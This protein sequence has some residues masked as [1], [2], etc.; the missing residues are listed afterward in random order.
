M[1]YLASEIFYE[2][3]LQLMRFSVYFKRIINKILLF[4]YRNNDII[5]ARM[6]DSFEDIY[7]P[8]PEKARNLLQYGALMWCAYLF[9]RFCLKTFPKVSISNIKK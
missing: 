8:P 1:G 4:L 6:S 7:P 2:N 5:A 9:L 3:M